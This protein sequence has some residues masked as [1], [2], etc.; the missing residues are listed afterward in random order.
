MV[1]WLKAW[2][3]T[4][5]FVG[6][7]ICD[8]ISAQINQ[9]TT[10]TALLRELTSEI[11][12]LRSGVL[13]SPLL[14]NESDKKEGLLLSFIGLCTKNLKCNE[15]FQSCLHNVRRVEFMFRKKFM[16][17]MTLSERLSY[18]LRYCPL[19]PAYKRFTYFEHHSFW[20]PGWITLKRRSSLPIRWG[21][22]SDFELHLLLWVSGCFRS[23]VCSGHW[24]RA[25]G[26]LKLDPKACWSAGVFLFPSGNL[27]ILLNGMGALF[28]SPVCTTL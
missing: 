5:P 24:E 20:Q 25:G 15:W 28:E 11:E 17:K 10:K 22:S 26:I 2:F 8:G 7:K 12:K 1:L 9:R 27:R 14:R 4:I 23:A 3:T 6:A 19:Y 16:R 21:N 13:S 18:V